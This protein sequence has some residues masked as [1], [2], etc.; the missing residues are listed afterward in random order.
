MLN[1]R[2][3]QWQA[4]LLVLPAVVL[5]ALFT[6]IPIVA[7]FVHSL[8][9]TPRPNRPAHFVG[10]DNYRAMTADPIFWQSLWNNF[11]YAVV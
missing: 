11:L 10:F 4:W 5:L 9:S 3:S 6:H 8:Y 2:G 7:T 1:A